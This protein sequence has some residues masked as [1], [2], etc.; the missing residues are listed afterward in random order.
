MFFSIFRFH[1]VNLFSKKN[2]L[3][4][5][6]C[7][8]IYCLSSFLIYGVDSNKYTT[9]V[10]FIFNSPRIPTLDLFRTLLLVLSF[11]LVCTHF[12]QTEI[13]LRSIYL[14]LRVRSMNLYFHSLFSTMILFTF[15]FMTIGYLLGF[16]LTFIFFKIDGIN[17]NSFSQTISS[18]AICQQYFLLILSS[19]SLLLINKIIVLLIK[20]SEIATVLF[21]F[22]FISS[23]YL[24]C[25]NTDFYLYMPFLYGFFNFSDHLIDKAYALKIAILCFSCIILYGISYSIYRRRKDFFS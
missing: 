8:L 16:L 17:G 24:V 7:L 5:I 6:I 12:M 1:Y 11:I 20:N 18:Y 4:M 10:Y 2:S 25:I 14:L 22:L 15:V 13:R 19:I 3:I 21:I 23:F 9:V